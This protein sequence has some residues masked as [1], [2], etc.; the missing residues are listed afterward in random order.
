MNK[1]LF[2]VVFLGAL[3]TANLNFAENLTGQKHFSE[4]LFEATFA[5]E[6]I[7]GGLGTCFTIGCDNHTTY[8]V[9]ARHVLDSIRGDTAIIHFRMRLNNGK[10]KV[11]PYKIPIRVNDEKLYI[12]H[13]NLEVDVAVL[14]INS[15]ID[16]VLIKHLVPIHRSLL[17]NE[18]DMQKYWMHPGDE[19]FFL[20]YPFATKS[21]R[22]L[23]PILRSGYISSYPFIPLLENPFIYIDGPVYKGNSGG[24]VFFE[25]GASIWNG[26]AIN[27]EARIFGLVSF[28]HRKIL[29]DPDLKKEAID[30]QVAGFVNS[31]YIIQIL[32]SIEC[33]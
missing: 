8:L 16:S 21:P 6:G 14:S 29:N 27:Q 11:L 18:N 31:A 30:I 33:R 3:L 13:K 24:P 7:E 22:G 4:I 15:I 12:V 19:V 20:G 25:F 32:D 17:A 1:W 9:T 5:I 23:F 26:R 28:S 2:L 10:Y